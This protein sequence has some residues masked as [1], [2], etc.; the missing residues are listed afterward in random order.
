[1]APGGEGRMRAVFGP[2]DQSSVFPCFSNENHFVI[3]I[4]YALNPERSSYVVPM[5]MPAAFSYFMLDR[6]AVIGGSNENH[7]VIFIIYAL[8]PER[9][10]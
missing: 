1:M 8:N 3:F 10:S 6:T 7:F 5:K 4:I 2:T 9:S